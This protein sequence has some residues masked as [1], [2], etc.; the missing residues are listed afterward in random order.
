MAV[1][2]VKVYAS[3][4]VRDWREFFIESE[5]FRKQ[6]DILNWYY[7]FSSKKRYIYKNHTR[8]AWTLWNKACWPSTSFTK[9]L[10]SFLLHPA[11][12]TSPYLRSRHFYPKFFFKTLPGWGIWNW[13]HR[14]LIFR[15]HQ[16]TS[17]ILISSRKTSRA[18]TPKFWAKL[19]NDLKLI[20][21][22]RE[23]RSWEEGD[24]R[25]WV[26]RARKWVGGKPTGFLTCLSVWQEDFIIHDSL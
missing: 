4:V 14:G 22:D 1:D 3:S 21:N 7:A 20:V 18:K 9:L 11:I 24:G 10:D 13:H 5:V 19:M 17:L 16:S 25:T 23:A 6:S 2:F 15:T 26:I 12:S 8:R